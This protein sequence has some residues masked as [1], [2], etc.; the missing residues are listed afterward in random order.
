MRSA[1]PADCLFPSL[2]PAS[3]MIFSLVKQANYASA[4]TSIFSTAQY[5]AASPPTSRNTGI[6]LATTGVPHAI[7]SASGNPKPSR[8]EGNK[9]SA[10]LRYAARYQLRFQTRQDENIAGDIGLAARAACSAV[11]SAPIRTKRV[12][13]APD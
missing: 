10:D 2:P 11:N 3:L 7:D 12:S 6:S 4:Q 8:S 5:S 9:V 13:E 1:G